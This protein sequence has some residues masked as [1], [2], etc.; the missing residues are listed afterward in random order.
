MPESSKEMYIRDWR[1]AFA[2]YIDY[3]NKSAYDRMWEDIRW[4]HINWDTWEFPSDEEVDAYV[5]EALLKAENRARKALGMEE[6]SR[7]SEWYEYT[8]DS[9]GFVTLTGVPSYCTEATLDAETIGLSSGGYLDNIGTGAFS[10]AKNLQKVVIPNGLSAI[11]SNA[12]AGV[13]SDSV[14]LVFEGWAPNLFRSDDDIL[15]GVPFS[16]GIDDSRIHIQVPEGWEDFYISMW[17]YILPA[18]ILR[19][20]C[21]QELRQIWQNRMVQNRRMRRF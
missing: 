1:Y 20:I 16:F 14:T 17:E 18:M 12:F 3:P 4:Q 10:K 7:L 11:Y 2:G 15:N 5:A 13:E 8:V 21:G 6:V 9:Y 19:K